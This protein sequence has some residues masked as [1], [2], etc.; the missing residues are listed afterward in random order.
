MLL[1]V[2]KHTFH[3]RGGYLL[4][5]SKLDYISFSIKLHYKSKRQMLLFISRSSRFIPLYPIQ[6]PI[7]RRYQN[8]FYCNWKIRLAWMITIASLLKETDYRQCKARVY[9]YF[10][11]CDKRRRTRVN[12]WWCMHTIKHIQHYLVC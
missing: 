4:S 5:H 2:K 8:I 6:N 12:R 10:C 3:T 1:P 11:I 9:R 7:I